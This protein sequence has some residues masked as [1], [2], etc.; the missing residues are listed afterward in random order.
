[1]NPTTL[2]PSKDAPTLT[3]LTIAGTFKNRC[4]AFSPSMTDEECRIAHHAILS[5]DGLKGSQIMSEKLITVSTK[6]IDKQTEHILALQE[7]VA[8]LLMTGH[9]FINLD[10]SE[11]SADECSSIYT[12]FIHALSSAGKVLDN[13]TIK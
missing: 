11:M 5:Y 7:T 12:D 8:N 4:I 13:Q 3:E 9:K 10:S 1:M 6:V 2:E